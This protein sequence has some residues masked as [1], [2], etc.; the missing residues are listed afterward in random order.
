MANEAPKKV[1]T[2]NDYLN[3]IQLGKKYN[4]D[5]KDI[6]KIM[7]DAYKHNETIRVGN[8]QKSK[9]F[10]DRSKHIKLDSMLRL[11]LVPQAEPWLLEKLTNKGK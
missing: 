11:R 1:F 4:A 9:V 5:P 10:R 2:N 8:I 7:M 6:H 3:A